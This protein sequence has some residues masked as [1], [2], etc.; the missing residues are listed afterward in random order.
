MAYVIGHWSLLEA[1]RYRA[2][3]PPVNSHMSF[4]RKVVLGMLVTRF[5]SKLLDHGVHL[6]FQVEFLFLQ[7]DFF[8]VIL[9]RHV[10]AIMQF[11]EL[12]FI[13]FVFFDQT[14]KFWIR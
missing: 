6:V 1:A 3:A 13:Q 9:L 2:C 4:K 11:V 5:V 10:V 8:K 12:T 7:T 14:A